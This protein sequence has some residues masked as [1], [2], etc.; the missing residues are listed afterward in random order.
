MKPDD[1]DLQLQHEKFG[2]TIVR[3]SINKTGFAYD[4]TEHI[5][6]LTYL[7]DSPSEVFV[8][9]MLNLAEGNPNVSFTVYT[10][11]G[12]FDWTFSQI[13]TANHLDQVEILGYSSEDGGDLTQTTSFVVKRSFW[14][15]L[16]RAELSK[17]MLLATDEHYAKDRRVEALPW[18]AMHSLCGKIPA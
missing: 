18:D 11:P 10:E 17:I 8:A 5:F 6:H 14:L 13:S 3:L 2:W 7:W 4:T 15:K 12:R 1:I 9:A 16:V